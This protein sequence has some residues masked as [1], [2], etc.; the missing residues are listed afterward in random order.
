MASPADRPVAVYRV[1]LAALWVS[2]FVG[3]LLQISLPVK[4]PVARL[5]DFPLVL[6]IYYATIR[7]S[8]IYGIALGAGLGLV[9]DA[10]SHGLIGIF[11]ISQC[12]VG[13]LAASVSV[14]VDLEQLGARYFMTALLVFVHSLVLVALRHVLFEAPPP[15]I[16]LDLLSAVVVN[17]ALAL[18]CYPILDRFKHPV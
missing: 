14:K 12:I 5:F 3:L 7:R 13:Y 1:N 17:V 18:I 2:L 6:T 16:P 11:G 15:F 10:L 8:K 4:L 9:Q